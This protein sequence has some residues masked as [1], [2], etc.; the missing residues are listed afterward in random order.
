[1]SLDEGRTWFKNGVPAPHEPGT[2]RTNVA[3]GLT[4]DGSLV[5][6]AAGWSRRRPVGEFRRASDG[7]ILPLWVC[8]SKD[9]GRSWERHGSVAPPPRRS[10]RMHPFGD[11]VR[12]TDDR[13][14]VCIYNM[15]LPQ[16]GRGSNSYFYSSSDDGRTWAIR[17]VIREDGNTDETTPVVLPDGR[18][19]AVA[20]TVGDA[21]LELFVSEDNGATWYNSGPVTLGD[22]HPGHLL[23]LKDGRLL[24]TYGIRNRGLYGVGVRLSANQGQTWQPPRILVNH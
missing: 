11:I 17:G 15:P 23:V 1:M 14:G 24:L 12:L 18:L 20:R 2:N 16:P 21:H 10:E 8:R 5:V 4:H 19:L 22:Q 13:L 7:D 3:V 6:L 9:G